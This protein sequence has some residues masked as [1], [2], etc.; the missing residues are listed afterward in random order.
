MWRLDLQT[1]PRTGL[2][3]LMSG[4][5]SQ[6]FDVL[7]KIW[8]LSCL[9]NIPKT[10]MPGTWRYNKLYFHF[11]A[12]IA[13]FSHAYVWMLGSLVSCE[14]TNLYFCQLLVYMCSICW[15]FRHEEYQI[16]VLK[17]TRGCLFEV[18]LCHPMTFS[19]SL[20]YILSLY[21]MNRPLCLLL[22]GILHPWP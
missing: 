21:I 3:T 15:I 11:Q 14:R 17:H 2:E 9:E 13:V 1:S 7:K 10:E 8:K 19:K 16:D 12:T 20:G 5:R 6:V 22:G 18:S 4:E